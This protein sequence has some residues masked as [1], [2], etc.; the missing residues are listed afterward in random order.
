MTEPELWIFETT[1]S[2]GALAEV[3]EVLDKVWSAHADVPNSVRS[4]ISIAAGE[5]AANII[6]HSGSGRDV[7]MRMEVMVLP[8]EV[9]VR[10]VDDGSRVDVDLDSVRM[11]DVKAE[12]GRGLA[13]AKAVLRHLSYQRTDDG[14]QWTLVSERFSV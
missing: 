14:N 4:E 12:R 5:I 7:Q 6:E 1:A 13:V 11:P 2:P 10:F 3:R 8:D 9:Q